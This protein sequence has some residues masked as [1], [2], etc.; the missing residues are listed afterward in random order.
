MSEQPSSV[1]D[2]VKMFLPVI[3]KAN[4]ELQ[5]T[6]QAQGLESVRIDSQI[7]ASEDQDEDDD[8]KEDQLAANKE[9]TND[10]S[11]L[12][13]ES[14]S[15]SKKSLEE[16]NEEPRVVQL[17]FALGDFDGTPIAIA[18]AAAAA[19]EKEETESEA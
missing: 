6:I 17:E 7:V 1:L 9:G 5:A 19:A 2:R 13:I 8:E 16:E 10:S 3:A 12:G 11:L 4:E 14:K 15:S 18:E